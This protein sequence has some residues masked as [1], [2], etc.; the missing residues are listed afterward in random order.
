MKKL[1]SIARNTVAGMPSATL[2]SPRSFGRVKLLSRDE[3]N[4]LQTTYL[5]LK[6]HSHAQITP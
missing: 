3:E 6:Y 4:I 5:A 1:T 2:N